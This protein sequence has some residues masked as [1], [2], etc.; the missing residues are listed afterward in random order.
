MDKVFD[1]I[2]PMFKKNPLKFVDIENDEEGRLVE[3][4]TDKEY[5]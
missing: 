4:V 5:I 1:S 2:L 3:V